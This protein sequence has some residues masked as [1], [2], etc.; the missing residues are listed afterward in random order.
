MLELVKSSRSMQMYALYNAVF[1]YRAGAALGQLEEG[2]R[3]HLH[4]HCQR[5]C[6]H[7]AASC[8]GRT[9]TCA[10]AP[11]GHR[12]AYGALS[13]LQPPCQAQMATEEHLPFEWS[14]MMR[15]FASWKVCKA[16]WRPR[17]AA[18]AKYSEQKVSMIYVLAMTA[19]AV[20]DQN[21]PFTSK[22]HTVTQY[23]MC[24]HPA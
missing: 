21:C 1:V 4:T 15:A 8:S 14:L 24:T 13:F 3:L 18:Y 16:Y 20:L 23:T 7:T 9:C 22:V 10:A 5:C 19:A 12:T 6:H 2:R 17:M 11:R